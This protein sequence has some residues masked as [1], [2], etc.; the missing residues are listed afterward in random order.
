M[1]TC[2]LNGLKVQGQWTIYERKGFGNLLHKLEFQI[3]M[4]V[5]SQSFYLIYNSVLTYYLCNKS[6]PLLNNHSSKRLIF[7]GTSN[8]RLMQ[9][10]LYYFY[11]VFYISVLKADSENQV[12]HPRIISSVSG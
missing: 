7:H 3:S 8:G 5:Y 10:L 1:L 6:L 11:I 9:V 4:Q 12:S 2:C